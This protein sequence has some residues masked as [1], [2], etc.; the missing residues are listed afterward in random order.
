MPRE[1]T[2][3]DDI[4]DILFSTA[5][6]LKE[7][8]PEEV[9]ESD[10]ADEKKFTPVAFH[11][12]C[13]DRISQSLGIPFVKQSRASYHSPD[14]KTRLVCAV[15]R[16]HDRPGHPAYWFS[17]HPHQ[18]SFLDDA[19][20]AYIAFGCGSPDQVILMPYQKFTPLLD[21]LHVTDRGDRMYWHVAIIR[22]AHRFT[23]VR[24]KGS[25]D[26]DLTGYQLPGS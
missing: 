20:A 13:V 12:A 24:R 10:G 17:F 22:D 11:R 7:E 6:D 18:Q 1:F 21:G 14:D 23:L 15:S 4:V 16:Q 19:D 25:S 9:G 26:V 8:G 5:E 3:L 2:R